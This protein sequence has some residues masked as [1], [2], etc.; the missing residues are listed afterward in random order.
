MRGVAGPSTPQPSSAQATML[1]QKYPGELPGDLT[2]AIIKAPSTG[3]PRISRCEPVTVP[4]PAEGQGIQAVHGGA[5]ATPGFDWTRRNQLRRGDGPA[6]RQDRQHFDP[7]ATP[8]SHERRGFC[9]AVIRRS[10]PGR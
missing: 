4:P 1:E 3:R 2:N 9:D 10:A 8:D 7:V 6:R 5:R